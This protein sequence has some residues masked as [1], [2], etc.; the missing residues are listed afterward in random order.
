V[1]DGEGESLAIVEGE[2][3]FVLFVFVLMNKW[4]CFIFSKLYSFWD[5]Y[6]IA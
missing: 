3:S 6:Y 5:L 1:K 4:Y 2:F